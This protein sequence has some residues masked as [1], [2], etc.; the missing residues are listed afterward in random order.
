MGSLIKQ[1]NTHTHENRYPHPHRGFRRPLRL[2]AASSAATTTTNAD[3]QV[4]SPPPNAA[5][6]VTYV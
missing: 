2:P 1:V 6:C 5:D 4:S 3:R